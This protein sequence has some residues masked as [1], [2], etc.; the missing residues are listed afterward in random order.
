MTR[1]EHTNVKGPGY[2]GALLSEDRGAVQ[3]SVER[4][5][6]DERPVEAGSDILGRRP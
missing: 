4:P 1:S 5:T 2:I 3:V 6:E